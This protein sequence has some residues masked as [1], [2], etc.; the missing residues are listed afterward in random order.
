MTA[1]SVYIKTIEEIG[2]NQAEA[3]RGKRKQP[4][5]KAFIPRNKP[6]DSA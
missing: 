5:E 6:A 4:E 2:L 3:E 1:I